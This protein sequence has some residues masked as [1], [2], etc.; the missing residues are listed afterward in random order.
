M[1]E[2]RSAAQRKRDAL[3]LLRAREVD[4][5]FA[6]SSSSG[7]AH[8]VPLSIAWDGECVLVATE[9]SAVT[10]KNLET[11]RRAR[12]ALGSTRDVVMI[13]ADVES[14]ELAIR[15]DPEQVRCYVAQAG[16]DPRDAGAEFVLHRLRPSRIQAWRESNEIADRTLMRDGAW[17]VA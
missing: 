10:T 7:L 6:T 5:W 2:P 3:E 11:G 1:A 9:P 4:G 16:W 14:T 17:L 8:L 15:V 12:I 13:D